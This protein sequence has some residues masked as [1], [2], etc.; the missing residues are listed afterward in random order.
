VRPCSDGQTPRWV[1]PGRSSRGSITQLTRRILM[2]PAFAFMLV[3]AVSA[4]HA[5]PSEPEHTDLRQAPTSVILAGQPFQLPVSLYR[6]F[7]PSSPA[8]GQPLAAVVRLP[9][10]LTTVSVERVWVLLG[11]QV[12]T[13]GVER[14]PGAQD[15]VA[16]GGPKWGPGV[17]VDVVARLRE[18]GG[19][20]VLARAAGRIIQ[21]TD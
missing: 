20:G 11:E 10:R 19:E 4:C 17:A 12:W 15:W 13:S 14:V 21:R 3:C 9:D 8:D 5:G 6:D 1:C 18:A 7:A 16:R 2:R